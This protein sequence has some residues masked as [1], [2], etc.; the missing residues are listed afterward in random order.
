[1]RPADGLAARVA[2]PPYDVVDRD[3]ARRRVSGNPMCFLRISRPDIEDTEAAAGSPESYARARRTFEDFIARGWLVRETRPAIYL[4]RQI[5]G[6]HVQTG[7]VALS[8]IQEYEDGRIRRHEHTRAAPEA[9]RTRHLEA[10]G[11]QPGPVFL[12]FRDDPQI[13]GVL[14]AVIA[15]APPFMDFSAPD[16]V[17]HSVWKVPEASP[18]RDL[19]R[20]VAATYIADGHHRAAAAA[21]VARKRAAPG[22][23]PA[24]AGFLSVLFPASELQICPYHR[25]VSDLNG[26]SPEIFLRSVAERFEVAEAKSPAGPS[27]GEILMWLGATP[28]RLRGPAL[29]REDPVAALDVSLLQDRLLAP[30]LGIQDPRSD[31]RLSFVGGLNGADAVRRRVEAGQAALGFVLAPV[32]IEDLMAIADRSLVMPPK[33]TWFEPKLLTG[34]LIHVLNGPDGNH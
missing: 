25:C 10:L 1:L 5:Q 17:R 3:E 26:Q 28:Y 30:V 8:S 34:L 20:G 9:D 33:S 27:P 21:C 7:V 31:E 2:C 12:A 24:S 11:A 23:G 13:A 22:D 18:L 16:G 19:F 4:Y 32:G 6:L 14:A 29:S 15:E